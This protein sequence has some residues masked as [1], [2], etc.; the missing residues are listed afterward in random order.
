MFLI[1][2]ARPEGVGLILAQ[3][4]P[5]QS[6]STAHF[7][8]KTLTK[9]GKGYSQI[10]KEALVVLWGCKPFHLYLYGTSFTVLTDHKPLEILY[11][12]KGKPSARILK[13]VLQDMFRKKWCHCEHLSVC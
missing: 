7:P 4:Q 3:E 9:K 5:D 13:W 1:V 6:L 12:Q 2:D 8:T 10:E 11:T